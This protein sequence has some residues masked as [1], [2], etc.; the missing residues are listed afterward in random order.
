MT[1]GNGNIVQLLDH[2]PYGAP[3]LDEQTGAAEQRGFIGEQYDPATSLSYLNA[4]YYDGAK[5]KFLSQD[6]SFAALIAQA[7][8]KLAT[9]S[10]PTAALLPVEP[11]RPPP[12]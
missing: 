1:D 11:R 10:V 9:E 6:P 8:A 2:Y 3:R 5:G 4:R 12:D 7:R